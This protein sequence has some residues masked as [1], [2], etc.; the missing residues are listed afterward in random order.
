MLSFYD[1]GMIYFMQIKL[2]VGADKIEKIRMFYSTDH[3]GCD[4]FKYITC[5]VVSEQDFSSGCN[6]CFQGF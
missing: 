4:N 6:F 3:T 2:F 5:F 1:V